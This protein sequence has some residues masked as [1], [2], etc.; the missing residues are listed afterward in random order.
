MLYAKSGLPQ[1]GELVVCTVTKIHNHSVFVNLDFY[2]QSAM[3]HISEV[4]PGRIRNLREFVVEGKQIVCKVLSINTQKGHIDVSLRRVSEN[5]KIQLISKIKQEQK[6]EKILESVA[7]DKKLDL[8]QYYAQVFGE[9]S[10]SY[11]FLFEAFNDSV[12]GEYVIP[13]V[14]EREY[15]VELISQR[16]KPPQVELT[17]KFKI[18]TFA[19]DG[20]NQLREVLT[21]AQAVDTERLVITYN[22][23]GNYN[24]R[25]LADNFKAAED[26]FKQAKDVVET[27]FMNKK[28]ALYELVKNEGKQLS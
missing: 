11:E 22:G 18:V 26:V 20:V 21:K 7:E 16:I 6:A 23:G 28:D 27:A 3:L 25:I 24:F 17:G 1:E 8:K 5:Q 9:I 2:K 19:N 15:L 13:Q 4:S 10:K 12:K 14:P